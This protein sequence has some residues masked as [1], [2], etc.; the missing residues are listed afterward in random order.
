LGNF[1]S[2]AAI[3]VGAS[4]EVSG[5]L[6]AGAAVTVG[7]SVIFKDFSVSSCNGPVGGLSITVPDN[8]NLGNIDA[9]DSVVS[10]ISAIKVTD[11][12]SGSGSLSWSVSV[13]SSSMK[14]SANDEILTDKISYVVDSLLATSGLHLLSYNFNSLL[15][16]SNSP[17]VILTADNGSNP[18][19][20][21]WNALVTIHVPFDQ[22][23]GIY[24]GS[25]IHSVY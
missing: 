2:A 22:P 14:N 23:Q 16:N 6:L 20:A 4:T 12:R 9:G 18:N 25:I 11:T 8:L 17:L 3:T 21:T 15:N 24:T 10:K 1:L 7:A 5:R 19:G 13:E